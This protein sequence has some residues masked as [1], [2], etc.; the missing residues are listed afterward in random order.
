MI[1][2]N[3]SEAAGAQREVQRLLGRCLLRVQQYEEL[4]KH[5]I[6]VQAF[7]GTPETI[8]RSMDARRAEAAGL[9]LGALVGRLLGDYIQKEGSDAP[10]EGPDQNQGSHFSFRLQVRLPDE[11]YEALKADLRALVT[12]RN[13]LVHHFIVQH[14]IQTLDGCLL[15]QAELHRSYAEIDRRV[16]QLSI[17]ANELDQTRKEAA[18]AM[19]SPEYIEAAVNGIMPDGQ[20]HWPG[21]GIVY[22]LRRAFRELSVD[23]WANLNVAARWVAE[24]EPEQTPK[25]FGCTS[26]QQA[27]HESGQFELR[28]FTHNGQSGRWYREKPGVR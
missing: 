20:I 21:A 26:W 18:K 17:F 2:F 14:D 28:H 12:L 1:D 9:T 16:E 8:H 27:V 24:Q 10:E 4:L 25:K 19:A 3:Q 15:A 7:S 5:L 22:V 13:S 23:G 6:A 11:S